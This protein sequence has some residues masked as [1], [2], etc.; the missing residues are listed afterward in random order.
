[1]K[2][3]GKVAIV[4]GASGEVGKAVIGALQKEG[5]LLTLQYHSR[6]EN[7]KQALKSISSS[8]DDVLLAKVDFANPYQAEAEV[9]SLVKETVRR[10]GRIDILVNLAG[11]TSDGLW[12]RP[13][14]QY[15][16]D[17]FLGVFNVDVMG[18]FLMCKHVV[19]EMQK[20]GGGVIV[21]MSGNSAIGGAE[22]GFGW[23][24]AKSAI[25]GITKSLARELGPLIR[26]N[27]MAPG[28]F[29]T[30]WVREG[31]TLAELEAATKAASLKRMGKPEEI[32]SLVVFL[33]SDDSSFMSGEI[34]VLDGG[35]VLR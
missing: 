32:A 1:M 10:F 2:L 19:P 17:D 26:V 33:A 16:I 12:V 13:M 9:D 4:T 25:I 29:D 3:K 22:F 23:I 11:R 6:V 5:T 35:T 14:T 7:L 18:T 8:E 15:S 24:V 27:A 34:L 21:N 20:K 28:Y 30:N 31:A